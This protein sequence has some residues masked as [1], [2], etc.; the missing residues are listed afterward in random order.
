MSNDQKTLADVLAAIIALCTAQ[1]EPNTLAIQ[2]YVE[3][4]TGVIITTDDVETAGN[5][6][7]D[8]GLVF[9]PG[10]YWVFN[11]VYLWELFCKKE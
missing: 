7:V 1:V 2:T 5:T 9:Q 3:H 4:H 11:H 8:S 10:P 6:L